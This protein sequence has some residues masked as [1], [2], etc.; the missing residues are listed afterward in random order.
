MQHLSGVSSREIVNTL[1]EKVKEFADGAQQSDDLTILCI[2]KQ[3][4]KRTI[5]LT[6]K[7]SEVTKLRQFMEGAARNSASPTTSS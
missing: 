7:L 3:A 5:V 2:G 4:P 1:N 6:N